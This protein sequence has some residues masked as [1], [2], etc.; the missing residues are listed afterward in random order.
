MTVLKMMVEGKHVCTASFH[1]TILSCSCFL[2]N[3]FWFS[4]FSYPLISQ[5][6]HNL[7]LFMGPTVLSSHVRR[8]LNKKFSAFRTSSLWLSSRTFPPTS[9]SLLSFLAFSL[10]GLLFNLLK[11]H[12][13]IYYTSA[14]K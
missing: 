12:V 8:K 4:G 14:D 10:S 9:C 1:W 3:S 7:C 2:S 13:A 6:I 11:N 5:G